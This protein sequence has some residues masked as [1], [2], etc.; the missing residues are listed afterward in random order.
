M[1][2]FTK[3]MQEGPSSDGQEAA[4]TKCRLTLVVTTVTDRG[5]SE[6][7]PTAEITD[8]CVDHDAIFSPCNAHFDQGSAGGRVGKEI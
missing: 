3:Y 5:K 7:Q 4:A 8:A 1:D 6:N 2:F